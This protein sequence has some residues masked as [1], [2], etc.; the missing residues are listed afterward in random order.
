MLRFRVDIHDSAEMVGEHVPQNL[1]VT[2]QLAV[3]VT[4]LRRAGC[5]RLRTV[6]ALCRSVRRADVQRWHR[7]PDRRASAMRAR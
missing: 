2:P 4:A 3:H 5:G 6:H 1:S 7:L